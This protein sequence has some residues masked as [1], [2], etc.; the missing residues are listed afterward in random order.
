LPPP[1]LAGFEDGGGAFSFFG[2]YITKK[3]NMR[4]TENSTSEHE[5]AMSSG[6]VLYHSILQFISRVSGGA[7][8]RSYKLSKMFDFLGKEYVYIA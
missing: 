7:P 2:A 1:D 4:K 8:W 5:Q 6:R 3:P